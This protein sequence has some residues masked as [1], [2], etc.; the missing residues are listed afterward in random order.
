MACF[1]NL[2]KLQCNF[3][4][5][6]KNSKNITMCTVPWTVQEVTKKI[7][8]YTQSSEFAENTRDPLQKKFTPSNL[9]RQEGDKDQ[10]SEFA[11]I[12]KLWALIF[13]H[14]DQLH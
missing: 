14:S 1:N 8:I 4:L 5:L 9:H 6:C 10:S 7:Q 2:S 13:A 3:F 12:C 11:I